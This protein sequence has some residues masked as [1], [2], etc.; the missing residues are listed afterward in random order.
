MRLVDARGVSVALIRAVADF[1]MAANIAISFE[2]A[3]AWI[4]KERFGQGPDVLDE[5]KVLLVFKELQRF[6]RSFLYPSPNEIGQDVFLNY[7][8]SCALRMCLCSL[9]LRLNVSLIHDAYT[10]D[11]GMNLS[12]SL[13]TMMALKRLIEKKMCTRVSSPLKPWFR[14]MRAFVR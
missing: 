14:A 12:N 11:A 6:V 1:F 8:F 7:L 2:K 3:A 13:F 10:P 9:S 4:A 5:S